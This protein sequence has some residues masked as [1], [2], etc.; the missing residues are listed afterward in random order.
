M[1]C[2]AGYIHDIGDF[3]DKHPGGTLL[4]KKNIAKDA[5][6][7]FFGGIYDHGHGAHNVRLSFFVL[8]S[9]FDDAN[10]LL[11]MMR[12][13]ILLGGAAHGLDEKV[14]P[15]GQHLR[16]ARYDEPAYKG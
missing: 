5:T 11:S 3:I 10:Q 13:A 15:P 9:S 4:L 1:V 16:V 6:T 7:A 12:V 14:V 8:L 2:I